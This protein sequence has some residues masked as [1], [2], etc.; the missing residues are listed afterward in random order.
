MT[1]PTL[2][3]SKDERLPAGAKFPLGQV[4]VTPTA[5][6]WLSAAVIARSLARA[7]PETGLRAGRLC[8]Y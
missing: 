7:R 3:T 2:T 6:E 1:S 8:Q 5:T 4:A